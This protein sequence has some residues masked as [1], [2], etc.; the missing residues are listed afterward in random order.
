MHHL[1]S[2]YTVTFK[3]EIEVRCKCGWHGMHAH[4]NHVQGPTRKGLLSTLHC[5]L[6]LQLMTTMECMNVVSGG[7]AYYTQVLVRTMLHT[8]LPIFFADW[9]LSDNT[10]HQVL[11]PNQHHTSWKM[12]HVQIKEISPVQ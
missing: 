3:S 4:I 9:N 11:F 6:Q 12:L 10:Y 1:E 5:T 2:P 8:N 7:S